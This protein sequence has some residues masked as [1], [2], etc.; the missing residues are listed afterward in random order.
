MSSRTPTCKLNSSFETI[1]KEARR[2]CQNHVVSDGKL[3]AHSYSSWCED[4]QKQ[5][6]RSLGPWAMLDATRCSKCWSTAHNVLGDEL[7]NFW[8]N[9]QADT[10]ASTNS[11]HTVRSLQE[12]RKQDQLS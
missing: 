12:P 4:W 11:S 7:C 6:E 2:D 8:D 5:R 3:L 1:T 10:L 9:V